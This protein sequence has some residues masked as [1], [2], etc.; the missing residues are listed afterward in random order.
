M[1]EAVKFLTPLKASKNSDFFF[2]EL[3]L[4]YLYH[5]KNSF[6]LAKSAVAFCFNS[7]VR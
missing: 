2:F 3:F 5:F 1:Q 7:S 4:F 6:P